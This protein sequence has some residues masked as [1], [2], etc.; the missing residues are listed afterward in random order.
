MK[1]SYRIAE[2]EAFNK[3]IGPV[4]SK[5]L[6]K[7]LILWYNLLYDVENS[8]FAKKVYERI[9]A[10]NPKVAATKENILIHLSAD[11]VAELLNVSRRT[12]R[13][14]IYTLRA[15]FLKTQKGVRRKP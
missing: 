9:K 12:A 10:E 4:R 11:E 13:D 5:A 6:Q 2:D 14:Y 7:L 1:M 15:I 3:L 8:P